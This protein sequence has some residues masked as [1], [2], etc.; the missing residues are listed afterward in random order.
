MDASGVGAADDSGSVI[1]A[2]GGGGVVV[3]ASMSVIDQSTS[4][5][6]RARAALPLAIAI[7][8]GFALRCYWWLTHPA[9]NSPDAILYLKEADNL[10][11]LGMLQSDVCMPL[12]PLLIHLTGANGIIAL[13]VVISTVSIYLGY[14]ISIDVWG[15]RKAALIAAFMLAVH[16]ML[17]YYTT[18]RLTETVFIFLVLIGFASIYRNQVVAAAVAFT[19][20][21]LTRPSLDLVFPAIILAATFATA[22]PSLPVI[23]RRL[24]I[25]ALVYCALMSG[26]WLHNYHKYHGFVR[27]NL[28]GGVT[29]FLE[30]NDQFQRDWSKL[31]WANL[32]AP[33][34][35]ISDPVE[36]DSAMRSAA[37]TYIAADP[38]RW[39]GAVVERAQLFFTP[40]DLFY[41]RFQRQASA[42]LLAI[43]IVGASAALGF[44][45]W[46]R[47]QLPLWIPV[48]FLTAL[49]LCFHA[50]PRYRLPL[51]PLLIIV[52]SGP[53]AAGS[54]RWSQALRKRP[55]EPLELRRG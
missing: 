39:L 49:H 3:L 52:A 44:R 31:D 10:F 38:V 18:F 51:D 48:A 33:F 45:A 28:G 55:K 27:L 54:K 37:I 46:W 26:W 43:M 15:G 13:Q 20:A 16:P 5:F 7:C 23:A 4:E 6:Q 2:H 1:I 25:F 29:M 12:Y 32:F 34:A 36:R 47:R 8:L 53:L 9:I 35:G 22:K 50:N 19:L 30:N 24:A 42:L 40:S 17:I 11:S 41:S 14:R 21:D